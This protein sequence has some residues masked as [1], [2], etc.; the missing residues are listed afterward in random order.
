MSDYIR[1]RL[2]T[3]LVPL[4]FPCVFSQDFGD[5]FY[6]DFHWPHVEWHWLISALHV[7]HLLLW[8]F[9]VDPEAQDATWPSQVSQHI[10]PGDVFN[11]YAELLTNGRQMFMDNF[12][13]LFP[14]CRWTILRPV[15]KAS[16]K[17]VSGDQAISCGRREDSVYYCFSFPHCLTPLSLTLAP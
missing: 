6:I 2:C 1:P 14:P 9:P 17:T 7:S 4:S 8:Y 13:H 5:Q 10:Q 12:F 16:W 15:R 11:P 3:T